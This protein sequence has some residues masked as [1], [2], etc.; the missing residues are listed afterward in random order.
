MRSIKSLKELL[1]LVVIFLCASN[2]SLKEHTAEKSKEFSTEESSASES[3]EEN[4]IN[5]RI[6][7]TYPSYVTPIRG[8]C[9]IDE[10]D[11]AAKRLSNNLK[12]FGELIKT[13]KF[14]KITQNAGIAEAIGELISKSKFTPEKVNSF[15]FIKKIG[16]T[17]AKLPS[18]K[19]VLLKQSSSTDFAKKVL[20]AK[21]SLITDFLKSVESSIDDRIYNSFSK[22]AYLK[23]LRYTMQSE[24]LKY[25]NLDCVLEQDILFID[26]INLFDNYSMSSTQNVSMFHPD[27]CKEKITKNVSTSKVSGTD[28]DNDGIAF[29]F[30]HSQKLPELKKINSKTIFETFISNARQYSYSVYQK[31]NIIKNQIQISNRKLRLRGVDLPADEY[32]ILNCGSLI[33]TFVSL[34]KEGTSYKLIISLRFPVLN[35]SFT[36]AYRMKAEDVENLTFNFN[37]PQVYRFDD[38]KY[39]LENEL[40][41]MLYLSNK[42]GFDKQIRKDIDQCK[43]E[44]CKY[45]ENGKCLNCF[46]YEGLDVKF[47][48]H[49]GKCVV[50]CPAGFFTDKI[51]RTCERCDKTCKTCDS[52]VKCTECSENYPYKQEEKCVRQCESGFFLDKKNKKC[53]K[54]SDNCEECS[55]L[56]VCTKCPAPLALN[57]D[58]GKCV[59][60]K[61]AG[62]Y[63]TTEKNI[64]KCKKCFANCKKCKN[65]DS[66]DECNNKYASKENK[67]C[68]QCCGKGFYKDKNNKCA[69]CPGN[70]SECTAADKCTKCKNDKI[71]PVNG[72]C[73]S[74]LK[75]DEG[76]SIFKDACH[77]CPQPNCSK[78]DFTPVK[79][80]VQ[81]DKKFFD[82]DG[83][84]VTTCGIGFEETIDKKNDNARKCQKCPKNCDVCKDGV[85]IKCSKEKGLLNDVCTTCPSGYVLCGNVCMRCTNQNCD[86]CNCNNLKECTNCKSNMYLLQGTCV[87]NCP[88]KYFSSFTIDADNG[89]KEL[90]C[91]KCSEK[92][93]KCVSETDCLQCENVSEQKVCKDKCSEGFKLTE[94]Y[95]DKLNAKVKVCQECSVA[96]CGTCENQENCDKCKS[97]FKLYANKCH[98]ECPSGTFVVGKETCS[99]CIKDCLI[100]KDKKTC[101]KCKNLI[102]EGK[103]VNN[104]SKGYYKK[105]NKCLP[106]PDEK[107]KDC[108]DN[109]G[110]CAECKDK[111]VLLN[112]RCKKNCCEGFFKVADANIC[113]AC[114]S[115]C[116]LCKEKEDNCLSCINESMILTKDNK[117]VDECKDGQVETKDSKGKKMC[118][119]CYDK[120][121]CLKCQEKNLEHCLVCKNFNQNGK[122]VDK[123]DQGFYSVT[124]ENDKKCVPCLSNCKTCNDDKTC[125]ECFD[126]L[127]LKD[128]NKCVN[129]CG[130]NY[131]QD[132]QSCVKCLNNQCEKCDLAN[133]KCCTQCNDFL[134]ECKCHQT[135][136]AGTYIDKVTLNNGLTQKVCKNCE[137]NA[138]SECSKEKGKK[139]DKCLA[140]YFLYKNKCEKKCPVGTVLSKIGNEC[141]QCGVSNCD[142]CN[143]ENSKDSCDKCK[144]G[145]FKKDINGKTECVQDCGAY[146]FKSINADKDLACERCG[147]NCIECD[148]ENSCKLCESG[149]YSRKGKCQKCYEGYFIKA[150]FCHNCP[151][152]CKS[153]LN[154][155]TCIECF[156]GKYLFEGKCHND[157]KPKYAKWDKK[158]E[159][160]PS[161]CD[162]CEKPDKCIECTTPK[163]LNNGVCLDKCEEGSIE[164]KITDSKNTD[165]SKVK[166]KC[167][168]CLTN[169]SCLKCSENDLAKCEQCK[170]DK[171]LQNEQCKDNCDEGYFE[172]ENKKCEKCS[173][174]CKVCNNRE[175]CLKCKDKFFLNDKNQC[176]E[177][178]ADGFYPNTEGECIPCSKNCKKCHS[179]GCIECFAD[180]KI[181]DKI[182]VKECSETYFLE[183][184]SKCEKCASNC[185][186]CSDKKNCETCIAP[187]YPLNG[188]CNDCKGNINFI[189]FL[190]T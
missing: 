132:K 93:K 116:K 136:P 67:Q 156:D 163:I 100:C 165:D 82:K 64:L 127:V 5:Q 159:K 157:C 167:V 139:C 133:L 27:E 151:S 28:F 4:Q 77:K 76:Y 176:V 66:C 8:K 48:L 142:K 92:C 189:N 101:D 122:C 84:C 7:T 148:D 174:N 23:Y 68:V 39:E 190:I 91:K 183:G 86:K 12:Y 166:T 38:F 153:C 30:F 31:S 26:P 21:E 130:T 75:C 36:Y 32:D 89:S 6:K 138:C 59:T 22:N 46:D 112:K 103:C 104:C 135:C 13:A 123:C 113:K 131:I 108:L 40:K 105:D 179:R 170:K 10:K 15:S 152:G 20:K 171:V 44:N 18:F 162:I 37:V 95:S 34:Q 97:P 140:G 2:S 182:C 63:L 134:H 80:C 29:A 125:L 78:C 184:K 79:K 43:S 149:L 54:C 102:E 55:N 58:T 33:F 62:L 88:E 143:P 50:A 109:S 177:N 9:Y 145:F 49:E 180:M 87:K 158:C 169:N 25:S 117:C 35:K 128:G 57:E 61:D 188:I 155:D 150:P 141:I 56:N 90:I 96:N 124:N 71:K 85:C 111:F 173:V 181:Q 19:S 99:D 74:E 115:P 187:K 41:I 60:C 83:K 110:E 52:K 81:C 47:I 144:N 106:C 11:S 161:G 45:A 186:K 160:C 172:N 146:Y 129:D 164:V 51:K 70:C 14:A 1:F 114:K 73:V 3:L 178:C 126:N 120:E 175:K 53:L 94:V 154:K 24:Y 72:K 168:K 147:P 185:L 121:N 16:N 119:D 118:L 107:C 17:I 137:V 65:F 42:E 69:V 98:R